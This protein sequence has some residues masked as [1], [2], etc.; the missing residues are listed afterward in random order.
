MDDKKCI[1]CKNELNENEEIMCS[2]CQAEIT[3]KQKICK[4]CNK[5]FTPIFSY[6][7]LCYDCYQK[8]PHRRCP[9]CQRI[10]DDYPR[11][12]NYCMDCYMKNHYTP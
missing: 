5:E 4:K 6:H 9:D 12:Q 3:P 7:E 8:L 10:I 1:K 11:H 2:K